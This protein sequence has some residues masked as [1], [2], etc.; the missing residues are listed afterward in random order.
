MTDLVWGVPLLFG[1]CCS[2]VFFL[3]QLVRDAPQ[4]S[5]IVTVT[6]FLFATALGLPTLL[7]RPPK[8]PRWALHRY[9]V[10]RSAVPW[11][12]WFTIVFLFAVTS[13]LN[14]LAFNYRVPMPVHI[15]FRSGGLIVSM[16]MN[17]VVLRRRYPRTAY[18]AVLLVTVGVILSTK[19]SARLATVSSAVPTDA[20][21]SDFSIG[22]ALL[23]VALV[24][25]AYLGIYQEE[26][27][28]IYG[29][30]WRES[31]F[32]SH[33]LA[34]PLFLFLTPHLRAELAYYQT[35]ARPNPL[36]FGLP[37]LWTGLA[38]TTGSQYLCIAAVHRVSATTS[39]LSTNL[40]LTLRKFVSL[41]LSIAYFRN[42]FGAGHVVGAALVMAG[43][44]LYA[45]SLAGGRPVKVVV[46]PS[47]EAKRV[48]EVE[49][50]D[51]DGGPSA[52]KSS[53]VA[54][55]PCESVPRRR[56]PRLVEREMGNKAAAAAA[57]SGSAASADRGRT[58]SPAKRR[59]SMSQRRRGEAE[60][61]SPQR[62]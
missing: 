4:S 23:A 20:A 60:P 28:R 54:V 1:G 21:L 51:E 22:I 35:H 52:G 48:V 7:H 26:T 62:S 42:P 45:W 14:N 33:C 38:L 32:F 50:D 8:T 56:S 34:L 13:V 29:G 59:R 16:A 17:L 61:V 44:A 58:A 12:R 55:A 39:S 41:I 53:A 31:L 47:E 30:H 15:I 11:S 46:Q 49:D 5:H 9:S 37:D 18:L 43:T 27:Y 57:R 24:L 2:N 6:Q 10:H 19:T 25:S 36:L 40:L 3:E